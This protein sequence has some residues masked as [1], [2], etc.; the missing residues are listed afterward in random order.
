MAYLTLGIKKDDI[1]AACQ[2]KQEGNQV[3]P[4]MIS[5]FHRFS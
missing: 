4:G 2:Q 1:L 3:D 5:T